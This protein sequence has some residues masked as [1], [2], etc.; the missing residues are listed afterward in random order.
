MQ[1]LVALHKHWCAADAVKWTVGAP[2][3]AQGSALPDDAMAAA[4]RYSSLLRLCV[5]YALLRVVVEGYAEL[6]L[7]DDEVDALLADEAM[8]RALRR[9]RNAVFHYQQDP[10]DRRLLEFL[11]AKDSERWVHRLH[12]AL[13]RYFPRVLPMREILEQFR[14]ADGH[15]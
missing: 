4:Q 1:E 10:L 7:G 3:P 8:T 13:G 11:E 15:P 5:W 9:F 2:I 14:S 6:R 12:A